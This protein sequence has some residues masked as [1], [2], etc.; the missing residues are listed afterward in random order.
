MDRKDYDHSLLR[1]AMH[2]KENLQIV[3]EHVLPQVK[4]LPV[5]E[6][7]D[8]QK[9]F[10]TGCGDSWLAGIAAKPAFESV[11]K[12]ET[13]AI[14]AI[15]FS[16]ILSN[17]NLGY[18]PNTPLVILISYSGSGSRVV[19]CAQRAVKYGANTIAITNNPESQLAKICHYCIDYGLPKDGEYQPGLI[20]YDAS[21]LSLFLIALRIGRVRNK[22]TPLDYEDMH[23]ELL[24][25]I[26]NC[27]EKAEGFA[28]RSFEIALKWKEL[29][30]QDFIG[31]YGDHATAY[32]GS[33]KVIECF[34]GY[35]TYDD[36]EDWCHINFFLKEPEKI[37]RVVIANSQTP[38]YGRLLETIDAI[39]MLK[40]P[41]IILT[42]SEEEFA[43]MEVF[44][45][46]LPKYFWMAPLYEHLPLDMIAG[47]IAKLKGVKEF[48]ADM[49]KYNSIGDQRNSEIV[50][51]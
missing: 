45:F 29:K 3:Y 14:R 4:K 15:E 9:I 22:I 28:E 32:F 41:C 38:S 8:A 30:A 40:S 6:L 43:G 1:Q 25:Y 42:D 17:K 27:Q 10:V 18:S 46:P 2:L 26:E 23:K 44:R 51:L 16:R 36:S 24:S 12:I 11:T 33:A 19:E 13:N 37:G 5:K 21:M 47:Y 35:T 39:K 49:E 34:G 31:D 7:W 20:T 48:R 50:V